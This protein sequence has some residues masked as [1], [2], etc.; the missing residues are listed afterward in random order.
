[1]KKFKIST[2]DCPQACARTNTASQ[3]AIEEYTRERG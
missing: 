3:Q 2:L 1:S